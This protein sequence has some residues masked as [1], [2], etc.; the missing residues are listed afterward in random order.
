MKGVVGYDGDGPTLHARKPANDVLCV[1]WHDL[2]EAVAVNDLFDDGSH[3]VADV[4][5]VRNEVVQ[6]GFLAEARVVRL[7][8]RRFVCR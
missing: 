6:R 7:N 4:G 2:E 5:V 1:S 3:V 8:D